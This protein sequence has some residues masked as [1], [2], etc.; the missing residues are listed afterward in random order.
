[1]ISKKFYKVADLLYA[2]A[3]KPGKN[4][5][6]VHCGAGQERSPLVVA[7]H[8][9]KLGMELSD[10]Y[11]LIQAKRPQILRRYDWL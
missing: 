4:K 10:A 6:L 11:D 8:L 5:I 2:L 9:Y 1:M 3:Y 7:L